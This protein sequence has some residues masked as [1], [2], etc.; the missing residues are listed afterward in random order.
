MKILVLLA[1]FLDDELPYTI[2][3]CIDNAAHPENIRFA[4]F[5]QHDEKTEN[6]VDH[7]PYDITVKKIHYT[8]SKGVGW[9]RDIVNQMYC[10]EEFILQIDSHLRLD[11]NW[12]SRLVNQLNEL[13]EYSVISYLSP[14]YHKD[15]EKNIDLKFVN[16]ET[17]T[18]IHI[19]K[20]VS[21]VTDWGVDVGGYTNIQDTKHKNIRV[22]FMFAGFIFA[23]GKWLKD[24]PS[25]P[26]MYYWG[27]EQSLYLR[28]WTNGYDI[29]LPKE[30][31]SWH[32]GAV[33]NS[34]ASPHHWDVID[35]AVA[36]PLAAV[37]LKKLEPLVKNEISGVYGLGNKRT[38]EQWIDF[39]GVDFFNKKLNERKFHDQ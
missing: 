23:R 26:D 27:E 7:L 17:P 39:S 35:K 16:R 29:Y 5:L 37:S 6:I 24:V 21:F 33:E 36:D 20:P 38:M 32:F 14:S 19:P 13:G 31:I 9:A 10:G 34:K 2:Q 11:K 12:D 1:S 8:E 18:S 3:S 25:D 28:S 15:K 4:V 30:I 22:P